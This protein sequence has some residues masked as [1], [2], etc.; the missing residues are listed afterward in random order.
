MGSRFS[1]RKCMIFCQTLAGIACLLSMVLIEF[2]SDYAEVIYCE[3]RPSW[4]ENF[5]FGRYISFIGKLAIS[6][7][8][9][10]WYL[11]IVEVFAVEV[12]MQLL[13]L[14]QILG[15]A[16]PIA[17][18]FIIKLGIIELSSSKFIQ[19]PVLFNIPLC[20]LKLKPGWLPMI[21]FGLAS[22]GSAICSYFHIET[23]NMP[24]CKTVKEAEDYYKSYY[25]KTKK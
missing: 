20:L 9:G 4:S 1:R 2:I 19:N 16:G 23:R 21:I 24:T 12:S 13:G 25:T 5:Q 17:A 22:L 3:I 14:S 10:M 18:P 11:I 6:A 15:R 8:F 7:S